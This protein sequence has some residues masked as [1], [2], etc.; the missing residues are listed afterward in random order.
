MHIVNL[1]KRY[2][3]EAAHRLPKAPEGHKCRNLHG[4]SFK[5]EVEIRGEVSDENAWFMDFHDIS[6][7]A[8]PI[9]EE[10]DHSYINEIPGLEDGTSEIMAKWI[11]DKLAPALPGLY[12]ISVYETETSCCHYYGEDK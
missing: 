2:G 8:K 6:K 12:R 4:H 3:F 11:W 10:L 9:A 1:T 7:I 5:F